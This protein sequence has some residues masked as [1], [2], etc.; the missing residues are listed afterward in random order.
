MS[1]LY[2][3]VTMLPRSHVRLV[4]AAEVAFAAGQ[5]LYFNGRA[6][7]ASARKPGAG[8]TRVGISRKG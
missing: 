5:C 7:V 1:N 4:D 8:W 6:L 2:P 3:V